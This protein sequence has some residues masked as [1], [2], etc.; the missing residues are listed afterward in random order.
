MTTASLMAERLPATLAAQRAAFLRD[1]PP[2][3]AQRKADLAKL[4][5]AVLARKA[6]IDR[7]L[8]A[9]FGHRSSHETAIM[10]VLPLIQGIDYQIRHLR[11]W[12]RPE[13]RHVPMHFQPAR[14]WVSYQPLGVVGIMAP[15]NFPISLALMPLATALAAGNRAIIKPSEF[16]PAASALL[17]ELI[18]ETFSPEQVAVVTGDVTVGQAFSALPF[19][20]LIFTGSTPVGRAVMKAASEN[21][22]PVTLELGGKSPVIVDKGH[23][24]QH[25]AAGIAFGKLSNGGQTCI[26]PDYALVH[27]DDMRSFLDV[28]D[29]AVRSMYPE[30]PSSDQYTSIVNQRQYERLTAL[31]TDAQ[32]KGATVREV[33]A[34]PD[35]ARRR[36]HTMAP[37]LVIGAT[38][39]MRIMKEEIFGPVLPVIPYR[40]LDE[41]ISYVNARP[42]PLALYYFGT[43]G[44][45]QRK[46]LTRTTS[47]NVTV[48]NTL[49]H[50]AQEDLPFG[51]VGPSGIGAYHGIE[52]FKALS[53]AKGIVEQGAWNMSGMLRP[54]FGSAAN[55]ILKFMLR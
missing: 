35:A 52:G 37:T 41:A 40:D 51:G 5:A 8:C 46:V 26:A 10:E 11:K 32:T 34:N 43:N 17:V 20:H 29:Q 53:H 19:D 15:W 50:Y 28:F 36:A 44:D 4:R 21:L 23:S 12:I 18:G 27:E 25:A 22:V 45:H 42:R 39:Q 49:M 38:D 54:P 3:L 33:G 48:N 14:A 6:D 55:M 31:L 9:D 1:G 2:T 24:L 7:A 30:G 13:R 47:G 16:A